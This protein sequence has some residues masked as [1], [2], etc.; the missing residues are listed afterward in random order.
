MKRLRK[1]VTFSLDDRKFAL[2]VS[3]VQRIIRVVEVTPLPKA[4]DIVSG[5]INMQGQVIPVFD[6]RMRFQ[7][8]A[9][10]VQLSDQMIIASTTKRTVALMVDSVNDVIEI[11]EEKIIAAEQ[12]LPEL[13]YV[14]GVMKTEDGMVLIHDLER[15]LSLPEEKALD[16]ALEALNRDERQD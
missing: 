8:P 2:Y 11:P 14:E 5:I 6:I 3:A 15:F 10:E 7:L 9:R 13:E 4:P 12:I 16:E 1:L